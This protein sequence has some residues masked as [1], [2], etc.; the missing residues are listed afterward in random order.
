MRKLSSVLRRPAFLIVLLL[1]AGVAVCKP[2]LLAAA[3]ERPGRVL[4]ELFVPWALVVGV[5]FLVGISRDPAGDGEDPGA[6][7]RD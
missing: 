3:G 2:V 4:L 1:V 6:P 5:L 7:E